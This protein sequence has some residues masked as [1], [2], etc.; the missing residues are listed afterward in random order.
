[1]DWTPKKLREL[2]GLIQENTCM[3]QWEEDRPTHAMV[4]RDVTLQIIDA[5]Y[6]TANQLSND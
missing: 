1:M 5:L 4:P 2:A 6:D 3:D